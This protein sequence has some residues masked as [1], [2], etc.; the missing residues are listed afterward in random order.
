MLKQ[1]DDDSNVQQVEDSHQLRQL[2]RPPSKQTRG[3]REQVK[4]RLDSISGVEEEEMSANLKIG[5]MYK[6]YD[7]ER[8]RERERERGRG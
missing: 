4:E 5:I 8:E 7:R 1:S 2:E 6:K 3:L